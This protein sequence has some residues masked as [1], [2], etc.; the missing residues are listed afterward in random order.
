[1]KTIKQFFKQ[2][3]SKL[4]FRKTN[5]YKIKKIIDGYGYNDKWKKIL[6]NSTKLNQHMIAIETKKDKREIYDEFT[7]SMIK[8]L[9]VYSAKFIDLENNKLKKRVDDNQRTIS[10]LKNKINNLE[11]ELEQNYYKKYNIT[12]L[13]EVK[14]RLSDLNA[15]NRNPF[16]G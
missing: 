4:M 10:N 5:D 14:N 3:F 2:I 15:Q 7:K 9:D 12:S 1:M 16:N 11:R 13:D 6:Y 8:I